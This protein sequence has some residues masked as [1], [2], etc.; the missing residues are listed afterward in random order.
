MHLLVKT[1]KNCL[2]ISNCRC[3]LLF[4][5]WEEILCWVRSYYGLSLKLRYYII[6]KFHYDFLLTSTPILSSGLPDNVVKLPLQLHKQNKI[7]FKNIFNTVKTSFKF[8]LY[9][10]PYCGN[11]F[12]QKSLL[13]KKKKKVFAAEKNF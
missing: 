4:L 12:R 7:M 3:T 10:Q 9:I 11:I 5:A 13:V 1:G 6:N 8:Y 2:K